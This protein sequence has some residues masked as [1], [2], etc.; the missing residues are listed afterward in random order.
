MI[1]IRDNIPSK[2]TPYITWGLIAANCYVFFLQIT[3]GGEAGFDKF[4]NHWALIPAHL[5]LHP[6]VYWP[7]LI[8]ATFL[9]GGWMHIIGNMVFLYIFGDNVE[10]RL[11][12]IKY[13]LFYLFVGA[14]AN[15]SQAFIDQTSKVPLI[16][17]SGA[18]AGVLGSYFY[19]YPHAQVLTLIPLG[20]FTR[21]VEIPAFVFLG[22]WFLMQSLSSAYMVSMVHASAHHMPSGGVAFL[23]HAAGFIAG[24]ILS[25]FLGDKRSRFK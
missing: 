13:L 14:L 11:G 9:H 19:Y 10:D 16:G 4:I 7:T 24:L 2:T 12:H 21:L 3:A 8:T 22:L 5:F 23:A 1:P 20:F 17:A 25:P 18:I 6:K 15:G